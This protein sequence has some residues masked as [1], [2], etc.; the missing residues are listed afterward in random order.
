MSG[1][2]SHW[3]F[4][5]WEC[6]EQCLFK[7]KLRYIEK[8]PQKPN[9]WAA[10]GIEIHAMG[11][12]YLL[13]KIQGIPQAFTSF[14]TELKGLKEAGAEAEQWANVTRDWKPAGYENKWI[15]SKQDA[16]VR[17]EDESIIIDFKSG[18]IY[19][20][21]HELQC[22][23]Y[24]SIEFALRPKLK[25]VVTECWYPD[26]QDV[27]TWIFTAKEL[28]QEQK[29]WTERGSKLQSLTEFPP[30]PSR[31]CNYCDYSSKEG[32]PCD[33]WKTLSKRSA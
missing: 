17:L 21:K 6:A 20:D 25:K 9:R 32:G 1:A 10:R 29:V 13:G 18:K 4:S 7:Y 27:R 2:P 28:K 33:A 5:A 14:A 24:A 3:S 22:S 15:V 19:E 12:N 23:L 16:R 26:Q 11:E 8:L 31:L 30:S